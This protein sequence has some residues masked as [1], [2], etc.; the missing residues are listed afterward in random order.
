MTQAESAWDIP[1][2]NR[3]NFLFHY[4]IFKS[5]FLLSLT[6]SILLSDVNDKKNV[7]YKSDNEIGKFS[8]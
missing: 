5:Y 3:K 8:Y 1:Y 2:L 7:I 4:Q 6:F